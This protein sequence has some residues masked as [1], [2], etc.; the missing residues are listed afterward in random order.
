[1]FIILFLQIVESVIDQENNYYKDRTVVEFV[2]QINV[3]I[4]ND[5]CKK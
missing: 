3:I 2:R 4:N 5:F 1:M